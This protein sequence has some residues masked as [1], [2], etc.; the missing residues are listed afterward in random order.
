MQGNTGKHSKAEIKCICLNAR[1]II[2][3]KKELN[4][5]VDDIK[6]QIIGI[7][8]LWANKDIIDAE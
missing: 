5:M 6:P 3:K 2:N 4:I 7:T 8:E 1:S